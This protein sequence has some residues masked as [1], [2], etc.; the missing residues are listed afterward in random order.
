MAR[1]RVIYQSEALY[2]G[3]T[4]SAGATADQ[5]IRVQDVSHTVDVARQDVNEFGKLA[6]L[7]RE[8]VEPPSVGTDF[9]Y[10]LTNGINESGLGFSVRGMG[11]GSDVNCVSGLIGEDRDV[12]LKNYYVKT[13]PE[14]AD[15]SYN[16]TNDLCS[17][18]GVGNGFITDYTLNAAVGDIPNVA[19]SLEAA[20]MNFVTGN[21]SAGAFTVP[22]AQNPAINESNGQGIS[23]AVVL[24]QSNT[25][26]NTFAALRPGDITLSFGGA[27]L[28]MGGAK[29]SDLHVQNFSFNLPIGR[30]SLNEIGNKYPYFRAVDFPVVA[31]MNASAILADIVE[32]NLSGVLCSE[33]TRDITA[34]FKLNCSSTE[35]FKITMKNATMDSQNLSSSIGDNKTVDLTF[36]A[37]I[38]GP[39]DATAGIFMSG[40]ASA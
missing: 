21:M 29:L 16:T 37:Q 32:G 9:T 31:T 17:I 27:E 12:I 5:L 40:N 22:A 18:I 26:E 15:A 33:Q 10:F 38:G 8:V 25:G 14:G 7:A 6:A 4:G 24:H 2:V 23:Q 39:Q 13:V 19:V 3:P 36:S 34:A 1:N 28:Q 11:F 20:N 30:S 35:A